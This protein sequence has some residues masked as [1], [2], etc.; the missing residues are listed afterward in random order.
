MI[1]NLKKI[2]ISKEFEVTYNQAVGAIKI[3][4]NYCNSVK[5]ENET[6]DIE[7]KTAKKMFD[8]MLISKMKPTHAF[9]LKYYY[10]LI[11]S[12]Q[13]QQFNYVDT[14]DIV[15]GRYKL[16]DCIQ[17]LKNVLEGFHESGIE[18][19]NSYGIFAYDES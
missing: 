12:Q 10:L 15:G 14:N 18:I 4:D 6:N 17:Q 9:Y 1:N 2:D 5:T 7:H 19:E 11:S 16:D 3:F 8:M 13:I